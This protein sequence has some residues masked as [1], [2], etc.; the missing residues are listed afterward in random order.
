MYL[1]GPAIVIVCLTTFL[2]FSSIAEA[3]KRSLPITS[4]EQ[5]TTYCYPAEE[6]NVPGWSPVKQQQTWCGQVRSE[7]R[8]V[9]P[10][11]GYIANKADW[12]KLWKTYRSDEKIPVVNFAREIILVY[13]HTDDNNVSMSPMLSTK[14]DLSSNVSFTERGG[15]STLCTYIFTSIDRRGIKTIAGKAIVNK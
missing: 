12:V 11:R 4:N 14:G 2:V 3:E 10:K 8:S 7:L 15:S 1:Q 5:K 9:A 13:T 6:I